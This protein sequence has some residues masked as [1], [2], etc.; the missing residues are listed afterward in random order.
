MATKFGDLSK[1]P[2]GKAGPFVQNYTAILCIQMFGFSRVFFGGLH[3]IVVDSAII[4]EVSSIVPYCRSFYGALLR[5]SG[6]KL[7]STYFA[8]CSLFLLC[9]MTVLDRHSYLVDFT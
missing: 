7:A 6:V 5:F 8:W 1:A 3:I 2:K 4:P 9:A